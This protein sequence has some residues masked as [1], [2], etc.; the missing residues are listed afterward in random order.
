VQKFKLWRKIMQ[1][2]KTSLKSLRTWLV[3]VVGALMFTILIAKTVLKNA[4]VAS[5]APTS[6][7]IPP[8]LRIAS[9]GQG[10]PLAGSINPV[11]PNNEI[12]TPIAP[13]RPSA[14]AL[15]NQQESSPQKEKG[16][17]YPLPG[18]FPS[19][20]TQALAAIKTGKADNAGDS[21]K[22]ASNPT[23]I[24]C[25]HSGGIQ[26]CV[27][28]CDPVSAQVISCVAAMGVRTNAAQ[29]LQLQSG[30]VRDE[31]PT[32]ADIPATG[33]KFCGNQR[34]AM[35]TD[36]PEPLTLVFADNSLGRSKK[37]TIALS[38]NSE[39][40]GYDFPGEI[41]LENVPINR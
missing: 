4:G 32:H 38:F 33:I 11:D 28:S 23:P 24:A 31:I 12:P 20:G 3:I 15:T 37:I 39:I 8:V 25:A 10:K 16:T 26:L 7:I 34:C 17:V 27:V 41:L 14:Q 40:N 18:A 21:T 1:D 2:E 13:A 9:T 35:Y 5:P 22:G 19:K 30:T 29:Y 36:H 6:D